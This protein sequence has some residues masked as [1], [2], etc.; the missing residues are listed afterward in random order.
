MSGMSGA[1]KQRS[2]AVRAMLMAAG[3]LSGLVGGAIAEPAL[4]SAS[5]AR[6]ALP[7]PVPTWTQYDTDD[8]AAG[9]GVTVPV[10]VWLAGRAAA[11][12]SFATAASTPGNPAYGKYLTPV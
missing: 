5:V 7:D 9:S 4:A 3:M 11:E 10:R 8:G 2:R 12:T 1:G 6:V